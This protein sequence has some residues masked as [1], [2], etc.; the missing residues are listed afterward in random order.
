M[1]VIV[2]FGELEGAEEKLS[3]TQHHLVLNKLRIPYTLVH[4]AVLTRPSRI[5]RKRGEEMVEVQPT[6]VLNQKELQ[7]WA[8]EGSIRIRCHNFTQ[9][10]V[11]SSQ[12]DHLYEIFCTVKRQSCVSSLDKLYAFSVPHNEP[13]RVYDPERE[14]ARMGVGKPGLGDFWRHSEVNLGFKLCATYPAH[15]VVPSKISDTTLTYAARHRSKG[16]LPVLC[17]LHPN[18]ASMTRSSQPMVGLK[19][20]RS[21]QD[22]KLVEAILASS[23]PQGVPRRYDY[24][25]NHI[26]IDARPTANAM[27][28]RALGAGSEDMDHYKRCKKVY[29]GIDN[30]HVMR[31]ALNRLVLDPAGGR[32]GWLK[33]LQNI[34]VGVKTVVETIS[35]GYHVLVHC[36]DGWDRTSQLTGLAQLCLDPYY[37]T[38]EGFMVL[39]EKEWVEF[40]HQFTLRTGHLGHPDKFTVAR[41]NSKAEEP[42]VEAKEEEEELQS[43]A[44]L[45]FKLFGRFASKTLKNMQTKITSAMEDPDEDCDPYFAKYPELQ[46]NGGFKISQSKHD[47]KTCPVFQQF[48]DCVYQLW[49][50]NPTMFEFNERFLLDLFYQLYAA[51]YG[52]FLG[53][54]MREREEIHLRERTN[55]VWQMVRRDVSKYRNELYGEDKEKKD[56]RVVMPDIGFIQYWSALFSGYEPATFDE[57]KA[58]VV[59]LDFAEEEENVWA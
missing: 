37:R 44:Q 3:L 24:E 49:V 34:M 33:H 46:S 18:R 7:Q 40:G 39:V 45:D 42:K 17:Y 9:L 43:P 32:A 23:E 35:A 38:I 14:F 1:D 13:T 51:E 52:T 54:S 29:L 48:L 58:A 50:Q 53:D 16:R 36:S 26:I 59:P 55:S 57:E 11:K 31:D 56:R 22:E 19:Q 30:I 2:S 27:A 6:A 10:T 21:V 4:S 28:N 20:A 12:I 47:H 15:L 25:R 41:A 5:R 8:I